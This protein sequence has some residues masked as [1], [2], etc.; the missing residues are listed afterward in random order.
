MQIW[1]GNETRRTYK[2]AH[3]TVTACTTSAKCHSWA[4]K[5]SSC[6]INWSDITSNYTSAY[7]I[8]HASPSNVCDHISPTLHHPYINSEFDGG[9]RL[10]PP[11]LQNRSSQKWSW[12]KALGH[13]QTIG[14]LRCAKN[15]NISRETTFFASVCTRGG[16]CQMALAA[17]VASDMHHLAAV[18]GIT[19]Y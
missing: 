6:F 5:K 9:L 13:T 19:F 7:C 3:H 12:L 10:S 1:L 8:Y 4:W 11:K 16:H 14:Y 18:E 15:V 17:P 2:P